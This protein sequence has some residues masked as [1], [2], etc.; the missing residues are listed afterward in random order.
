MNVSTNVMKSRGISVAVAIAYLLVAYFA[1]GGGKAVLQVTG[2]LVLPMA[3]IW[4]SDDMGGYTGMMGHGQIT[5]I[6]PG[7]FVAFGGW[8]VLFLPVIVGVISWIR[9]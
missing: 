9:G 3:C 5:S 8:L 1:G 6:T 4:F 2:F 7:C